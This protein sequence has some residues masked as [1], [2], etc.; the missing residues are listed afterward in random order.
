VPGEVI[1]ALTG[2][3]RLP[4]AVRTRSALAEAAIVADLEK[5]HN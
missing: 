4:I 3:H 5:R 1:Y 2:G